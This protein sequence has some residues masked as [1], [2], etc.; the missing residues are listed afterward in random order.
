MAAPTPLLAS[1]EMAVCY[2]HPSRETGVS[3][4]SCGR[5]ICPDCMTPTSV[6]MRCPECSRDRTK[7]RTART[8]TGRPVVTQ[9][10]IAINV[11]AFLAEL[12]GGATLSSG[13]GGTVWNH[14]VLFG[15]SIHFDHEYWRLVTGGF[16]HAGLF[17]ILVNMVSLYFVGVVLEPA[18]GH[19]NFGAVYFASLLA[20]SFGALLFQPDVPTVGASGAI[21]GI[22]GALI[23][24]AYHRGIPIWQSG[25]GVVLVLNLVIS[26]TFSGISI[27][28]HLGGLVAGLI[29]GEMIVQWT[30]RRR[31]PAL[32]FAGCA[33]VGVLGVILA[34][35]VAG[36]QGLTPHGL[37]L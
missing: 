27:G 17:H 19:V 10:L 13:G 20:G 14:G 12:A 9:A 8:L 32:A 25:L 11:I 31:L 23:V 36:S 33:V 3:C 28:G 34:I 35:A 30:E 16:L 29:C 2:R 15:P 7:V 21:F 22:F 26:L 4:S 5:P 37:T 24:V 1:S 6:G 18:I